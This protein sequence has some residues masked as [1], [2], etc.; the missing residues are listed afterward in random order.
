MLESKWLFA[1]KTFSD[2]FSRGEFSNALLNFPSTKTAT[3]LE[4]N[5]PS[6]FGGKIDIGLKTKFSAI[7]TVQDFSEVLAMTETFAPVFSFAPETSISKV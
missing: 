5:L 4:P 3:F 6:S 2:S 7:G 1:A